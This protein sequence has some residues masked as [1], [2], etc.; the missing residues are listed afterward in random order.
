MQK[1]DNALSK[2]G[3]ETELTPDEEH[4]LWEIETMT[5]SGISTGD[6]LEFR[7]LRGIPES[8]R[9]VQESR[10][11]FCRVH[12]FPENGTSEEVPPREALWKKVLAAAKKDL[13]IQRYK[14]LGG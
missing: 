6:R 10:R 14:G 5:R 12:L 2:A 11:R 13:T 4:G 7:Q 8:R 3:Y 9:T 1:I